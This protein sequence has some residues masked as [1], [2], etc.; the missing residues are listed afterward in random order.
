MLGVAMVDVV[1]AE[2]EYS[3]VSVVNRSGTCTSTVPVCPGKSGRIVDVAVVEP[4]KSWVTVV[5]CW[6]IWTSTVPVWPGRLGIAIVDVA[7]T[8]PV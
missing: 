6:G 7:V 3:E 1:I 8:S 5:N 2:P 4:A